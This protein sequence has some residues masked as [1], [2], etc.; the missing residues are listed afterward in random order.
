MALGRA[1]RAPISD[2]LDVSRVEA[3]K[4][5][6]ESKPFELGQVIDACVHQAHR[7]LGARPVQ[8]LGREQA[9]FVVADA[10]R[11][12]Q[13]LMNLLSNA[14]KY[15]TPGSPIEVRISA[16]GIFVTVDVH[17]E[18]DGIPVTD[19]PY[20]FDRFYRTDSGLTREVGGV[21]LGLFIC[22]RLVEVMGGELW[23]QSLPGRGCTL[24]LTMPL[25]PSQSG[26]SE[27]P[28]S[29]PARTS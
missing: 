8:V 13:V 3:G 29:V 14:F 12:E 23:L 6:L 1:T 10:F 11:V 22:K 20:V 2:L 5:T 28:G 7:E 25:A 21:G 27:A 24:S 15:S 18:G 26:V 9:L 4:L 19:Q 17:N 16:T